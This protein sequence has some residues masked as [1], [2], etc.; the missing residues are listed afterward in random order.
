MRCG[1]CGHDNRA[2]ARF[3]DGCGSALTGPA[4]APAPEPAPTLVAGGRYTVDRL[5]GEGARKLVYAAVDTRLGRD[6]ALAMVKTEGL[7]NAGRERIR[8]EA[9]AMARLGDHPHIVTVFDVGDE[10]GQPYIVSQLMPGGS[11]AELLERAPDH[12]VPVAD[13]LRIVTEIAQALD[14]AHGHG[15]VH[16]DLKPANV[17]RASDGSVLLGDFGLAATTDQSRLTVDGLVVGTVAY[18]APEQAVGR[19]PDAR[20]DLYSLGALFYELLTGRPPFLGDDAVG[21]ISQHLNTAPVAPSW[22]NSSVSPALDSLV[23]DLL[24]KD[25]GDR[26]ASAAA[27]IESLRRLAS[28]DRAASSTPAP[29][30]PKLL[31]LGRL[32]GRSSELAQLTTA[33]D[34]AASGRARLVMVVGEPG[35]GKSRLVEELAVYASVRGATVCWG[36]CYEGELGMPYLPFIEAFR[37]YVRQRSDDQLRAELSSGGP[38]VATL[39]SELRQRFGD[40]PEPV[41]LD[42]DAERLRLFEGVCSFVRNAAADDPLVLLLDDLHWADKP[43][44]LMLQYMARNLRRDRVLIVGTYRDVELDRAHPLADAVAALRRE[45]LYERVLLRG[46]SAEEVK[47]LIDAVDNQDSPVAFAH[48]IHRETE[49]NPFF[50][51]EILRNL[52][53]TGALVRVD[54]QWTGTPEGVAENLPEGVREVIGRRLSRL[55]ADCNRMLTVGAAMPGGFTLDAVAAVLG[56]DEDETLDLLDEALGAQ[57][58]R[59]RRDAPGTY[60]F[61]HALI[62]QT[63]YSELST[64]RRVRLHRQIATAIEGRGSREAHLSELAFHCFHGAAGGDVAKAV[65]YARR[66]GD[67]ARGQAAHEEAARF[68]RMALEAMELG[69]EHPDLERAE[70]LL[71]LGEALARG[72]DT[73]AA[74]EV[75]A[76]AADIARRADAGALFAR[77]ALASAAL[78]WTGGLYQPDLVGIL[79][80]AADRIGDSDDALLARLLARQAS[81]MLF[82]DQSRVRTLAQQAVD[83]ADRSGDPG[84]RALALSSLTWTMTAPEQRREWGRLQTEIGA[85]AEQAGDLDLASANENSVLIRA[86]QDGD[87]PLVDAM[88]ERVVNRAEESRSPFFLAN[89]ATI[90]AMVAAMDGRYGDAERLAGETLAYARRLADPTMVANFGVVLY[91]VWRERGRLSEFETATARA[92][93]ESPTVAAWRAGLAHL[94]CET[95]KLDEARAHTSVLAENGFATIPDDVVRP[96]ALAGTAEAVAALGD[97]AWA[98][99]LRALLLP[100][101]GRAAL[102]GIA[103]YHGSIDRYLGLLAMTIGDDDQAV[104]EFSEAL[105]MHE[106]MGSAPWT[107]R[108]QYDLARALVGRGAPGDV[109]RA[110]ALLNRSLET[111]NAIGM[112]KL[113]EEALLVKLGLQ[114]VA[115]SAPG[116][117]IDAI[118]AGV[119]L[120]RPDLRAHTDA[121]GRVTIVFSDIAGYTATTERLGDERTQ[122]LLR[123]HNQILRRL[124]QQHNGVE[125]KSQGDGFMLAFSQ[126]KHGVAFAIALQR[127]ISGHD[128]DGEQLRLRIGMHVGTVIKEASDFFGRTVILAARVTDQAQAGEVLVTS[129]IAEEIPRALVDQG[130]A[131]PLKGLAGTHNV[132]TVRWD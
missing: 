3:C 112:S 83:A 88:L 124:V 125:V 118:A 18:L 104:T 70:L 42:G 77:V 56:I 26:P 33:F 61:N 30:A 58:V 101:A 10:D 45:R 96:Y 53:E 132:H 80:E 57:V 43:S 91:P 24:A 126:P 37:T 86:A 15:V 95:G 34:E 7:D 76:E 105:A 59:E 23:L 90:Q 109:D 107:A 115:S 29:P 82:I 116:Q 71:A 44:L 69:E 52:V 49:G 102:I 106:R 67:R 13:A 84:A 108:T 119:S 131:V 63:L 55:S 62:R 93:E 25:P 74:A 48:L 21:V 65:D 31:S 114:G 27:L 50:V 1:G 8:R 19:A 89:S 98:E 130:R 16:R 2:G 46:L 72:G 20:S 81:F 122:R 87:R 120:E 75:L 127:A 111:A 79:G 47:A 40:L 38:E 99:T 92:V 12:R 14:H 129:E 9:R 4:G 113:V 35:I 36:H 28:D 100:M 94:L 128:F 22:H 73:A 85:L 60:E 103:A 64:P 17:W 51:A 6:V 41:A 123:E 68:Y 66:A 32:I 110:V 54:G 121:D 5:I 117:S 11:V 39:V 97:A 78:R